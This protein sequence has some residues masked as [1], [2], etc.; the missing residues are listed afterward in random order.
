MYYL[1]LSVSVFINGSVSLL[2]ASPLTGVM[3]S[4]MKRRHTKVVCLVSLCFELVYFALRVSSPA[5][6]SVSPLIPS[7][8]AGVRKN[9]NEFLPVHLP[10][11][12]VPVFVCDSLVYLFFFFSFLY[13][14]FSVERPGKCNIFS[15]F[16]RITLLLFFLLEFKVLI[17]HLFV[18][19]YFYILLPRW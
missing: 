10:S 5:A 16:L 13:G 14:Y 15:C 19:A 8:S 6:A 3:R 12:L 4:L 7:P 1:S 9:C 17:C 2:L 18:F 11:I